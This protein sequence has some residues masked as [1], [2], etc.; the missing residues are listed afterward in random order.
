MRRNRTSMLGMGFALALSGI[1]G[2]AHATQVMSR[3]LQEVKATAVNYKERAERKVHSAGGLDLM[4][5]GEYGMSPMEY[6]MRYGHGNG[7]GRTNKLRC[8]HNAKLKRR[9]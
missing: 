3:S 6:G 8:S 1:V 4:Q 2:G 9:C 7:K 5:R